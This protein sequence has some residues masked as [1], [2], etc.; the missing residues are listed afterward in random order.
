LFS[1]I[2]SISGKIEDLSGSVDSYKEDSIIQSLPT[3]AYVNKAK[4]NFEAKNYEQAEALLK[5]ALDISTQDALVYKYLGRI[6][7]LRGE[8][9]FAIGNYETALNL[10]PQD[11][12]LWL[13]LGMCRLNCGYVEKALVAI[14]K[15]NK[16]TPLNT[17]VFTCWGMVLMKQKK[18][19][20]ARDKFLEA[21][22]INK[23]NFTAILLSAIMEIRLCDYESAENK[24]AFL[25]KVAPNESSNYEY[26][27]LKLLK[28]DYKMAEVFAKKSIECNKQMLP[29]YLVLGEVYSRQKNLVSTEQI[30]QK[31][32]DMD[33]ENEVLHN[34]WGKAYIRFFDF[35]QAKK[36][37]KKALELKNDYTDAKAGLALV[38]ANN[39]N[40]EI[41]DELKEKFGAFAYI[42][43]GIG[44]EKVSNGNYEDAVEM[45]KKALR[46]DKSQSYNLYHLAKTYQAMENKSKTGEYFD[47]FV[48]ENPTYAKGFLEY[49]K[50]LISISDMADA[51]RKL[52]KASKLDENN[53]EILN[54]LF[55]VSYTLVKDNICE[56]N[57]KETISLAQKI[58]QLG[59]FDYG[60]EL[61]ELETILVNIQG[62]N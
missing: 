26:A 3:V 60:S 10:N 59:N 52:R 9:E 50:W 53:T 46:T 15:A 7:E 12:D 19:A 42:Q 55:F 45:F 29:A 11:K 27:N 14:E 61:S 23:Y 31:A 41:L 16:I 38:E 44:L 8:F 20:L 17:D 25:A 6:N 37:F 54:L 5:K 33:L 18:Y 35:E 2:K 51:Q 24:L 36:H 32:V 28:H 62:S 21:S 57:V 34:E 49:G 56:Y 39:N 13:W 58:K 30:F 4:K 1:W 40:F 22:R 47:K 48:L 43:E